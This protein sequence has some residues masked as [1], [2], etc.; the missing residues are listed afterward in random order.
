MS[1]FCVLSMYA[2][3]PIRLCEVYIRKVVKYDGLSMSY[4]TKYLHI[5]WILSDILLFPPYE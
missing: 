3:L 4:R 2:I 5:N 1:L